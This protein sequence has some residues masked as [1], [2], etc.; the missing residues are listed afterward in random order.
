M[1]VFCVNLPNLRETLTM[2]SRPN[3]KLSP[4][5]KSTEIGD[6]GERLAREHLE[7]L[8]HHILELKW[9]YG[10]Y[11]VD[12]ISRQG[13]TIV[14]IEVKTRKSGTFGD[15]EDFVTRKKQK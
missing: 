1:Q 10:R 4:S 9:R 11:E 7:K 2:L 13:D 5:R 15:P 8:G 12:I 6:E 3:I 14:F